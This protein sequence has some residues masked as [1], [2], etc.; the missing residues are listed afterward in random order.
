MI[1]LDTFLQCTLWRVARRGFRALA[2]S[3]DSV[4]KLHIH[5]S[6]SLLQQLYV[7][8]AMATLVIQGP[9]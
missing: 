8:H 1:D 9:R 3:P 4:S 5:I 6:F 7:R 2:A